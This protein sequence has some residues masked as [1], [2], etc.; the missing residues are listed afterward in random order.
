MAHPQYDYEPLASGESI[1]LLKLVQCKMFDSCG[2]RNPLGP[3]NSVYVCDPPR[4][5]CS[6]TQFP[7]S[8]CRSRNEL[9]YAWGDTST[10]PTVICNQKQLGISRNLYEALH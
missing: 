8:E 1:R 4:L 5:S 7:L 10:Q 9:S 2:R 6:I 3:P